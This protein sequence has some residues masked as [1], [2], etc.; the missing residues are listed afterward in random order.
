LNMLDVLREQFWLA[1]TPMAVCSEDCKGLCL[2][3]GTDLNHGECNCH[4]KV[5][6]NPFAALKDLKFDA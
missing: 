1:W 4:E 6:D 3:C 2:Q 5:K